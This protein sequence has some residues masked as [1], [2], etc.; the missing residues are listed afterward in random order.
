[1]KRPKNKKYILP[2][3]DFGGWLKDNSSWLIPVG[4][5]VGTA[6][7]G[8]LAAP[9]LLPAAGAA[10]AGTAAAGAIGGAGALAGTT[11]ATAGLG[12]T[13]A[14]SGLSS[15]LGAI[16]MGSKLAGSVGGAIEQEEAGAEQRKALKTRH[17]IDM[18][19]KANQQ[20]MANN[21]FQPNIPTYC[22]GGK[23]KKYPGGGV[24]TDP[25]KD[26]NYVYYQNRIKEKEPILQ[27]KARLYYYTQQFNEP[28]KG[29]NPEVYNELVG[30]YGY[31]KDNP[32]ST[33]T[34]VTGA[35]SYAKNNPNFYLSPEEQQ[36]VLGENWNDY[37]QLRGK[38]GNEYNLLGEG[39]DP[40]KP[41][42]WK[43]GARHAVAFN[44]VS[45][46]YTIEP[47]EEGQKSSSF[48]HNVSYD[49]TA[50]NKYTTSLDYKQYAK[51]GYIA[52]SNMTAN[53]ELEDQEIFRT[54]QGGM[55]QLNGATHAEGGIPMNLP[56]GTEILGKNKIPGTNK[57]FKEYG[58]KLMKD[59]NK[60]TKILENKPTGLARKTAE[61]MLDNINQDYSDT[62]QLQESMKDGYHQMPNGSMM[63]NNEMEYAKGGRY[64]NKYANGDTVEDEPIALQDWM[65]N[66]N[67][68]WGTQNT[69]NPLIS[70]MQRYGSD[71][72]STQ[73]RSFNG[74]ALAGQIMDYA[75]IAYNLAQGIFNKPQ[76]LRASDYYNPQEG[77]ATNLMANRRYNIN[78]ELEAN[79]NA[80]I[81]YTRAL[82]Q[83]A[84]S[85][86]QYLGNIQGSQINRSR[87]DAEAIARQQN[88]DNA[89][90]GEE[91][92][93]RANLGGQRAQTNMAIQDINDRNRSAARS[94]I[95]TALSQLQQANQTNRLMKNLSKSDKQKAKLLQGMFRGYGFNKYFN[96]EE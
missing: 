64:I 48:M 8:G 34:R 61:R 55:F 53:S 60:Y 68:G 71:K 21:K 7:T 46:N 81:N 94:Y 79:R 50:E 95:P 77:A 52:D 85:Q 11:A 96:T 14:G 75:P 27:D 63:A 25:T 33:K 26:P 9:A 69:M 92:Q 10:S 31:N 91:A 90:R 80:Q 84:P 24:N 13:A 29:K 74:G 93:M 22:K 49:P 18:T 88:M 36:K 19:N 67:S 2:R 89:Y 87:A 76:N 30:K 35:D 47:T 62:M 44:P 72:V 17:S 37:N 5:A 6:L 58:A 65:L 3:Y 70:D 41:E 40:T 12:A 73:P 56:Q 59:Y 86:A 78:P 83:G 20:F 45:Y 43:V 38:Y 66:P 1:M 54:P 23:I 16:S 82:R 4:A 42:T 15:T 51:G 57:S 28:L 32:L 39:D